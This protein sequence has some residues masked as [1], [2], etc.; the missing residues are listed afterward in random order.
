MGWTLCTDG[1][2][3]HVG[4]QPGFGG[5]MMLQRTENGVVGF[6]FMTNSNGTYTDNDARRDRFNRGYA[7]LEK[8]LFRTTQE[9]A[10]E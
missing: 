4:G 8:L 5:T 10:E 3:G 1:V 7:P 9:M 2:E 6:L